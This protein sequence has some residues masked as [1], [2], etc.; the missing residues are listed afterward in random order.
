M[1][2]QRHG[3]VEDNLEELFQL[4]RSGQLAAAASL[5][6]GGAMLTD[7]HQANMPPSPSK[8][9]RGDSPLMLAAG[10]AGAENKQQGYDYAGAN[11]NAAFLTGV[12]DLFS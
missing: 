8:H 1:L 5:H 3:I 11:G 7:L 4:Q 2:F 10:P 12:E 6:R 9:G